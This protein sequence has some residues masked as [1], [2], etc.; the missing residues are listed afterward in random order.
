MVLDSATP[1]AIADW[2]LEVVLVLMAAT[3]GGTVELVTVAAAATVAVAAGLWSSPAGSDPLW[4]GVMNRL[5]AIGL[6]WLVVRVARVRSI[7]AAARVRAAGEV[8]V[9]SGLLPICAACK[10]IRAAGGEWH[11]LEAYI[12][13]HSEARFTHTYC[14]Q[15]ADQYRVELGRIFKPDPQS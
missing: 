15:C 4:M 7:A 12:N 3:W 5:T 8:K 9:L 1:L 10:R 14:P 2:L 13:D 6:I 11:S